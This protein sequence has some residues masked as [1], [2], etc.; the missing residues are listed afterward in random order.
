VTSRRAQRNNSLPA[1]AG[2]GN[3]APHCLISAPSPLVGIVSQN[4]IT[5]SFQGHIASLSASRSLRA[6]RLALLLP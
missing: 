1:R 2:L 5:M 4:R 3:A 6:L